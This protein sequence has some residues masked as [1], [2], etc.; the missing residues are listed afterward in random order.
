MPL[1]QRGYY[2]AIILALYTVG[3]AV[4]PYVGG[5]IADHTTWRWVCYSHFL[6]SLP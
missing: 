4:G 3:L 6:P 2:L 5:V 1:R